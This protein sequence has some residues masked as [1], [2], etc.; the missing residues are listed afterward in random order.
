M[1]DQLN[2]ISKLAK[3]S[4]ISRLLHNPLDYL[5]GMFF[6]KVIYKRSKRGKIVTCNT[7]FGYPMQVV[8]PAGMDIYL[9]GGKGH[10]S[11]IRLAKLI[12]SSV[13]LKDTF[14]DIGAHFGYFSL[15]AS[16]IVGANGQVVSIEASK[17]ISKVLTE[18][19]KAHNN[20][21]RHHL[22]CQDKNG[23]LSFFE[24]PVLYSEYN[25]IHPEQFEGSDWIAQNPPMEIKVEGKTLDSLLEEL[26]IT[27]NFIKID[28]EGAEMQVI[29]GMLETLRNTP[30]L[31]IAMEY[32]EDNR[33]N[34]S[35]IEATRLL[36]QEG[37]KSH[38]IKENGDLEWIDANSISAYLKKHSMES[39]NI[40]FRKQQ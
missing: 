28:V 13:K 19:T 27:P 33:G 24:F 1:L 32:L 16:K 9:L 25:T 5:N 14:I 12:N 6:S 7:I 8:L 23:E 39:D 20:I 10:D 17:A 18:N 31:T 40:V 29:M 36:L 37:Y 30:N 22:A 4:K 2:K 26:K 3:S 11:E 38:L 34:T 21:D 15:M 35:H